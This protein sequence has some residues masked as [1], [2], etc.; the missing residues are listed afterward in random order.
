M[1]TGD[2]PERTVTGNAPARVGWFRYY[3]A[4]DRWEWSDEVAMLHGYEPGTI[5]PT[6]EIVLSHRHPDDREEVADMLGQIQHTDDADRAYA[7]RHRI[8]DTR[9]RTHE[10]VIIGDRLLDDTGRT[11]GARGFCVDMTPSDTQTK[12]AISSALAEI[13]ENRAAIEQVK[14]MLMLI[15]RVDDDTAFELLRWRSQEAN[16]KLRLLAEQLIRDYNE[17]VYDEILPN[18][19]TFDHLLLTAHQ[20][21]SRSGDT[22]EQ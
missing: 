7:T 16:V 5:T 12:A 14:G 8:I 4:D 18:R 19:A 20:R 21:M 13:T 17:L 1:S 11:I 3:F 10:I 2:S 9:G 15:Y 6:T 22:V